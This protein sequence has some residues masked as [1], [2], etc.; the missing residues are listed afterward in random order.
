[1]GANRAELLFRA[2]GAVNKHHRSVVFTRDVAAV[3]APA[4]G[5]FVGRRLALLADHD[6]QRSLGHLEPARRLPFV[7]SRRSRSAWSWPASLRAARQP[8]TMTASSIE[9]PG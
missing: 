9:Q 6:Q 2:V 5:Q 3:G 8:A 4:S 1:M 7:W